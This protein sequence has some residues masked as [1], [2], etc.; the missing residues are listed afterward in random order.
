MQLEITNRHIA[1]TYIHVTGTRKIRLAVRERVTV[2][3][4][5]FEPSRLRFL[6]ARPGIVIREVQEE[7]PVE[8][9]QKTNDP[10]FESMTRED[11]E[12]VAEGLGV[13]VRRNWGDARLIREIKA[14]LSEG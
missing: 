1:P 10:G 9:T 2:D 7:T 13:K 11:L 14:V 8:P 6:R 3:E 12:A 5:D 4:A